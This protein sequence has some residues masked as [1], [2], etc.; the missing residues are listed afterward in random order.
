MLVLISCQAEKDQMIAPSHPAISYM[1]RVEV[2]KSDQVKLYW[3][4]TS[5]KIRFKGTSVG[6]ILSDDKGGN[7]YNISIDGVLDT[8]IKPD[9]NK[10]QYLLAD[11]LT[12]EEHNVEIFKR[13][14]WDKGTTSFEG[15]VLSKNAEVLDNKFKRKRKIEFYGNSITAGY[16]VED[17]SGNDNPDGLHTNNYNAYGAITARY[18]NAEY[19]A[20]CKS[21]IGIMVSW[22]PVIMPEIYNRIN[23][24]DSKSKWDFNKNVPDV[25]VINLLQNDS[26]LTSMSNHEEFQKR[27]GKKAPTEEDIVQSYA[28]FVQKIR[29]EYPN[30]SIVCMLGNMDITKTDKWTGYVSAAVKSLN[31]EKVYT[32]FVD[33]K[34]TKGHPNIEEQKI[35]AKSLIDFIEK[36][37]D[38]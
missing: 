1:G 18:F 31:D 25:V 10:K 3:S 17:F 8:I 20:I 30:T 12:N 2:N 19:T 32:H 5:V 24:L 9:R 7:Y 6:A 14:E 23:P 27:F 34:N 29:D 11:N 28:D 16:A 35:L 26:W 22:H 37:I 21:G 33:F 36:T 38:W 13:T 15:F 4:G